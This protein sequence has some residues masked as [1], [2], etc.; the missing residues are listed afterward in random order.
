[1]RGAKAAQAVLTASGAERVRPGRPIQPGRRRTKIDFFFFASFRVFREL[2]THPMPRLPILLLLLAAAAPR[3]SRGEAEPPKPGSPLALLRQID[4]GFV[5][6]FEKVAPSVVVIE[7]LKKTE[8]NS[9][10]ETRTLDFFLDDE[11]EAKSKPPS[12]RPESGK[13]WRLPQ[14]RS[15]GSGFF[16]RADGHI[17][18]NLHVIAEADKVNVRLR[19]G[20]IFSAKVV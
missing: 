12:A 1:M 4:E 20:R 11:K 19:D 16:L 2:R 9:L 17:V 3:V 10:D 6:V 14:Q 5:Q 7:V 18:T 8:E 15:E 13:G